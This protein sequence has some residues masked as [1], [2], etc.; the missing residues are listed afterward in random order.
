[1]EL[2]NAMTASENWLALAA[3]VVY[4]CPPVSESGE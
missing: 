4:C 2:M 1:M 3:H